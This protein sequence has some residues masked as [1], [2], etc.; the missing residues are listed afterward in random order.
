ML[1]LIYG[2]TTHSDLS[3]HTTFSTWISR[4]PVPLIID[5][6]YLLFFM[7]HNQSLKSG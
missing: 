7:Q 6:K 1:K 2:N 3:N 4:E 5:V